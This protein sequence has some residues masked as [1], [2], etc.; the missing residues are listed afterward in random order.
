MSNDDKFQTQVNVMLRTGDDAKDFHSGC[1]AI[2]AAIKHAV[3]AAG[4]PAK[5]VSVSWT[6]PRSPV[7]QV[8]SFTV[9]AG[10]RTV[11]LEIT[12]KRVID[13]YE[14]VGDPGLLRA[15]R[16]LAYQLTR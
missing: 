13:S 12:R 10:G 16:D 11:T 3:A 15:I 5:N 4:V 9:T 7:L 6:E 1:V 2:Q 14:R 8:G